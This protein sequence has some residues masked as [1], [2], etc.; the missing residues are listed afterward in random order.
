MTLRGWPRSLFGRIL[1]VLALGLALA[2]ALTFMLA[3]TE[4]SMTMRRAMVSY[5]A[6]DVASSVAMLER[7]SGRTHEVLTSVAVH[8]MNIA[9]QITQVS[10]VRFAKLTPEQIRAY[11]ASPEPYDKAGGYGIQGAAAVFIEHIEGSHSGIMGLPL[12]ETAQLL[13]RTA[14]ACIT[15]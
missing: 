13:R 4:R 15:T 7:L 6:S 3:F 14:P 1:L 8:G 2:H 9:E 5:F 12:F 11:C 10:A